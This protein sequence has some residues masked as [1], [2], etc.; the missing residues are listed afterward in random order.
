M[1]DLCRRKGN[2]SI[3]ESLIHYAGGKREECICV[4]LKSKE[5]S[6]AINNGS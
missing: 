4:N 1:K 3:R 6:D 2:F 5:V